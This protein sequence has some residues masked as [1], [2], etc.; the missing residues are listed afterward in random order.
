MVKET[1]CRIHHTLTDFYIL[2][3]MMGG[4]PGNNKV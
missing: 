1:S 2:P 4:Y 3:I